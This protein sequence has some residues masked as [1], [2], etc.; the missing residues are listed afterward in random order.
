MKFTT[1][2]YIKIHIRFRTK[3]IVKKFVNGFFFPALHKN[4]LDPSS[5][6]FL[7]GP[8]V[9]ISLDMIADNMVF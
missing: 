9:Y 8:S 4:L 5:K 3:N 1:K 2:S 7:D 6:L